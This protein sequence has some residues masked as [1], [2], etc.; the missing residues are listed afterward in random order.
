MKMS[1]GISWTDTTGVLRAVTVIFY[2]SGGIEKITDDQ[3]NVLY[4][5][6]GGGGG[7]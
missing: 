7:D 1:G 4:E 6:E 2:E 3:G 5:G